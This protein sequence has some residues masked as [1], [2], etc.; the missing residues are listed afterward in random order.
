MELDHS[1]RGTST[2][3]LLDVAILLRLI[4]LM[5][6]PGPDVS[7]PT[8]YSCIPLKILLIRC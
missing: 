3:T 8:V 1:A 7:P 5:D 4:D 2:H 6:P